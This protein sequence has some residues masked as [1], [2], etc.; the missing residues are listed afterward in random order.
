MAQYTFS[1]LS[2]NQHLT[3][4]PEVDVLYFDSAGISASAVQLV[5]EGAHIRVAYSGKSVFLD[6]TRL[7]EMAVDAIGFANADTGILVGDGTV[8]TLEDWYGMEYSLDTVTNGPVQVWGLGGADYITTGSG[9]DLLVGNG[10][11]TA[12]THVS[13]AGAV[14]SPT[15]SVAPTISADGNRVAFA[16]G[17]TQFGSVNNNGTDVFVKNMA[18]GAVSNEHRSGSGTNGN[19]GSGSPVISG[20]GRWLVFTSASSNLVSAPIGNALYNLYLADVNGNGITHISTGTGGV[21]AANGRSL[22]PDISYDGRYVVFQS[23]TSNWT[24]G[25]NLTYTDILL[26]DVVSG[27]LTRISTS[28]SGGDGNRDN[29]NAQISAD[30]RYVVFESGASN[31]SSGDTNGYADIFVW[32]RNATSANK[33]T[34]ITRGLTAVSNPNNGCFHA[35]ISANGWVVFETGRNLLAGDIYNSTDIYAYHLETGT[36]QLVSSNANGQGVG[37]SSTNPSISGDGRFVVFVGGSDALVP[38]D[39]NGVADIFV[40][41]LFTGQI[42]LVSKSAAGVPANLASGAPR[43]SLGGEWIVFESSA[44]TLAATD[45]NGTLTD[46]FRVANPLLKDTLIGGT[47][48][49]TYELNRPDIIQELTNGGID[50]VR[51]SFTYTLGANLENLI[52]TGTAAI[53]GNG[54]S[55]NNVL[56]GNSANNRLNGYGGNDTLSGGGGNDI[57]DG[58]VGNDTYIFNSN[59]GSIIDTTLATDID[60]VRSSVTWTL[61]AYLENLILTGTTAIN[62][63]GNSGNNVLTGNSANNRLNGYGGNDTLSGGGGNDI[64]DGGVGNDTYIFNSNVGS[65]IDTTLATDIDTVRSSVTWTLQAYLENLILTGT[66]AINGSGN[67]GNNVLTGNSAANTLNGFG[68]NDTLNGGGGNDVLLGGLGI[69]TLTGGA[70]AD[71]F[72]FD[73]ALNAATNRDTMTDF[74]A[75]DDTL[76]LDRTVFAKLT[77]LGTLSAGFFRASSNGAAADGNDYIL[78]NTTTGALLYDLDGNGAAVAI[79]FATLATKPVITAADCVVIA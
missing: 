57:L 61:Q 40:K 30:G 44:N 28:L 54:N 11:L 66:T 41:D 15:S 6:Q 77:T 53:N 3:F 45:A 17:W 26:K 34:N 32:D 52:L 16:G 38:G 79:P 12:L 58:G 18:T 69:D 59:V 72:V 68:G 20:D 31:L 14:G 71:F 10:A 65:I 60:T 56:T 43:I 24:V 67:S 27:T 29:L 51:A 19:S 1:G 50:T 76:R 13:R 39:T 23:D 2:H 74:V 9:N 22:N 47:G 48:N 62:G 36:L 8:G 21:V 46:V 70:G 25:G 35:D 49:D 55:A 42:A 33:L 5:Q 37:V 78:Y 73:T 7:E 4:D 75:V 64:L 63:S